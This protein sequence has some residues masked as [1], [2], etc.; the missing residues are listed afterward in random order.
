[1]V[2]KKRLH[3]IADDKIPFLQGVLEPFA[4]VEYF[5]GKE[6]SQKVVKNADALITRTRTKVSKDLLEGSSVK[7]VATATIGYDHLDTDWL[8]KNGI[9]WVNSPGCNSGSVMQYIGGALTFLSEKKQFSFNQLTLGVVGVGNVGT[10]VAMLGKNLGLKVLLNDPPRERKEGKEQF[11][12]LSELLKSSDIITMHVPLNK[13]GKDK[14]QGMVNEEFLSLLKKSATFINSSRGPVVDESALK[15]AIRSGKIDS[16]VL[17]VWNNEP[18]IDNEL[19]NL[20][21]IATPHIAGYSVD[22]KANGT[23][24]VVNSIARYFK[25]D[26]LDWYPNNLPNPENNIIKIDCTGISDQQIQEKAIRSTYKIE[27]DDE[28]LRNSIQD[29][30]KLRGNYPVRREFSS[31]TIELENNT[32]LIKNNLTDLGFKTN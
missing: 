30:E 4:N 6:I 9:L 23:S 22:G 25:L 7:I 19:L 12:P 21:D 1:M 11:I 14:T 18:Q 27:K 17:D 2:E 15:R 32:E 24:M 20:I 29:F 3:I 26:L 8:D 5:P 16:A 31:Y 13:D 28:N 10:K